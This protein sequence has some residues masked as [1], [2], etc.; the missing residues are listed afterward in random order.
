MTYKYESPTSLGYTRVKVSGKKHKRLFP[1]MKYNPLI[2]RYEYY[3]KDS[4]I[5]INRFV[6]IWGKIT[7]LLM[8]PLM[9]LT[10]GFPIA[11][12]EI[13]ELFFQKRYG[14]FRSDDIFDEQMVEAL[15]TNPIIK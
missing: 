7:M 10:E 14:C 1:K 15:L 4:K 11:F 12:R 8:F 3:A 2:Y 9:V 6:T 5:M 13:K